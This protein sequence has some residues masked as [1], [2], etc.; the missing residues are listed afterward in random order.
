M[1][2][3]HPKPEHVATFVLAQSFLA[4]DWLMCP[5]CG[6]P[7]YLFEECCFDPDCVPHVFRIDWGCIY[8]GHPLST[9]HIAGFDVEAGKRERS[10]VFWHEL[11]EEA[12]VQ[13][14]SG[15]L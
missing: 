14:A 9:E 5:A 15:R 1:K 11:Q 13:Y 10:D 2:I 12:R 4:Q 7:Q 6:G 8:C 3:Y